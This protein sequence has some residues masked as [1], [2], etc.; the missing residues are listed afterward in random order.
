MKATTACYAGIEPSS[1]NVALKHIWCITTF[2][3]FELCMRDLISESVH[4]AC[5]PCHENLS[6]SSD[7]VQEFHPNQHMLQQMYVVSVFVLSAFQKAG[8]LKLVMLKVQCLLQS[9]LLA[10]RREAHYPDK[11]ARRHFRLAQQFLF[12]SFCY[13]V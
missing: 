4:M 6:P 1:L 8:L 5:Y 7:L 3:F 10:C 13:F 12:T 2:T 11:F 9:I